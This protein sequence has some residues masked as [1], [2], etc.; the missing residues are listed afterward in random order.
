MA[1]VLQK[2]STLILKARPDRQLCIEQL[3]VFIISKKMYNGE[4]G[5]C[6]KSINRGGCDEFSVG[7]DYGDR[8]F[9]GI[10]AF[11]GFFAKVSKMRFAIYIGESH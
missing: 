6:D 3:V 9:F 2:I 4:K 8:S 10:F 1:R 11:Y 5:V 7:V